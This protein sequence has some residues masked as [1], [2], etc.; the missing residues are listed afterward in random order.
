VTGSE[1]LEEPKEP[2]GTTVY[3]LYKQ[4]AGEARAQE[5]AARLR[6]GNY[7]WGHAKQELLGVLEEELA[8]IRERYQALRSDEAKLDKILAHGAER[9]RVISR[10]TMERVRDAIGIELKR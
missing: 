3:T 1:T 10:A 5:L 7:G 8:P 9:A 6:A 4:V 2:E